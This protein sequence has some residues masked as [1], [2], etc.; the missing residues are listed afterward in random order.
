VNPV[1]VA[2]EVTGILVG[3]LLCRFRGHR[4]HVWQHHA[5]PVLQICIRCGT[6]LK[7]SR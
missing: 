1:V 4:W 7:E 6:S 2:L 5:A 3:S